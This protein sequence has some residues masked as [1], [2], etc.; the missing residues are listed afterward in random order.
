MNF[1]YYSSLSVPENRTCKSGARLPRKPCFNFATRFADRRVLL[2][3]L[4]FLVML[5]WAHA[6]SPGEKEDSSNTF[7]E[8]Q[9]NPISVPWR[10]IEG[11][12]LV[13]SDRAAQRLRSASTR[14]AKRRSV[15]LERLSAAR[16]RQAI[17][18]PG[19]VPERV[20]VRRALPMSA[21]GN[22]LAQ[23]LAWTQL[24]DGAQVGLA[25]FSSP[26]ARALRLGILVDRLPGSAEIRFFGATDGDIIAVSGSEITA[27]LKRNRIAGEADAEARTYWSP[28]IDGE[29]V[30]L[31][32]YLPAGIAVA[33]LRAEIASI[34]HLV[35][36]ASG[37]STDS[38][39]LGV[40]QISAS[41]N[42]DV[43]CASEWQFTRDA[44]ARM[45]FTELGDTYLCSGTLI[46]DVAE[47]D[48]PYFLTA[49]HC[50]SSQSAASSLVTNWFYQ[51]S[52]C[53]SGTLGSGAVTLYGGATLLSS[54]PS[55]DNTL[56]RLNESAPT[57]ATMA[58]WTTARPVL[59]SA[60]TGIHH[61]RGDLKKISFG[62]VRQFL[63]CT[64]PD[65]N[66]NFSCSSNPNGNY[67]DIQFT[68]GTV[69]GGSS[70]SGI[71]SDSTQTLFGTLYGGS[72]TCSNPTGLNIYGRFDRA[73]A[74]GGLS[75]WLSP[76]TSTY[77]LTVNST[78]AANVDISATP[79]SYGGITN[80]SQT[81][82]AANTEITLVAPVTLA[83]AEFAEWTGCDSS[84]GVTCSVTV[85]AD[86]TLAVRYSNSGHGTCWACLPSRGGWRATLGQ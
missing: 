10:Q 23:L 42:L 30:G 82:I 36:D 72:A 53:N 69:E 41:C 79:S 55:V 51:A 44:V 22:D 61:P 33:S 12:G 63:D 28:I 25:S 9:A 24:D 8:R 13:A 3:L 32:V 17:D 40:S 11:S 14:G 71:F 73:Y 83:S 19:L 37:T 47:S 43:M 65:S 54:T 86:L 76:P 78:G 81:G 67:A 20:G 46:N 80:Y 64:Q 70:G 18:A 66:G 49:N 1:I 77:S 62:E 39:A 35:V 29:T 60:S 74:L 85:T 4:S 38:S 6:A 2:G 56:L 57:G 58:A 15:V 59:G 45:L 50:I 31:E 21:E 52:T 7:S 27:I 26:G 5:P 68:A 84:V 16:L 48:I 34:S 75:A